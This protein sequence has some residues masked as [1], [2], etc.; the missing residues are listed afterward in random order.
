M[1]CVLLVIDYVVVLDADVSRG[2]AQLTNH[3][4]ACRCN[5]PSLTNQDGAGE[6]TES[7]RQIGKVGV[8]GFRWAEPQKLGYLRI[9]LAETVPTARRSP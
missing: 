6:V 1:C 3:Y 7:T 4:G 9:R 8:T 5:K 2:S